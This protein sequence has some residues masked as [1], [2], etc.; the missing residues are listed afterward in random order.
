MI[1]TQIHE[2]NVR[3]LTG[4]VA[5]IPIMFLEQKSQNWMK[6]GSNDAYG[7][8]VS[9]VSKGQQNWPILAGVVAIFMSWPYLGEKIYFF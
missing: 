2:K 7:S 4:S 1:P 3:S 8:K 9:K 6:D 5:A